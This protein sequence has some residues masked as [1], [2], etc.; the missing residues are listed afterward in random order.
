MKRR[1]NLSDLTVQVWPELLRSE[2]YHAGR[3]DASV[4]RALA[5]RIRRTRGDAVAVNAREL[6][7]LAL[8]LRGAWERRPAGTATATI[9]GHI[10]PWQAVRDAGDSLAEIATALRGEAARD[11]DRTEDPTPDLF[12]DLG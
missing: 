5:A 6:E 2:A 4:M 8:S 3:D 1:L 9:A 10:V 12:A 11:R 7:M